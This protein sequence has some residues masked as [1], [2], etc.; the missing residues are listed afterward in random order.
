MW[1]D[2]F[3]GGG[4]LLGKTSDL[5]E[6]WPPAGQEVVGRWLWCGRLAEFRLGLF[7]VWVGRRGTLPRLV[8]AATAPLAVGKV[9][10]G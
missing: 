2:R 3:R 6:T 5:V 7:R 4:R 1:L 8:R 9:E 10:H